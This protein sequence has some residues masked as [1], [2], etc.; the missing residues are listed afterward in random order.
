MFKK[1]PLKNY[2]V[3]ES[4]PDFSDNTYWLFRYMAEETNLFDEFKCIWFLNDYRKRKKELCGVNIKCVNRNSRKVWHSFWRVYYSWLAKI[5]VDC[6]F[7]IY[8]KRDE[9]YRI[10]LTHGMPVKIPDSYMKGIGCCDLLPVSGAGYS[11]FFSKYVEKKSIKN[12][13]LPRND[14]LIKN[15]KEKI[16]KK[17]IVWM[18]TFRQHRTAVDYKID[19]T[20]PLGIPVLKSNDDI[21]YLNRCLEKYRIQIMFRPHPAQDISFLKLQ[22]SKNIVIANDAYLQANNIQLYEF[23]SNSS[24]LIT[25]YSSIY[26][27]YLF[28]NRP[29]GLTLEDIGDF[30][31]KWPMFFHNM[32]K[33]VPGKKLITVDDLSSFIREVAEGLDTEQEKRKTFMEVLGMEEK[34]SCKEIVNTLFKEANL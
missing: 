11:D 31:K 26:L 23:V 5:I 18:P 24:A 33:S 13:G 27:D 4:H 34:E 16:D 10:H 17:Y 14:I 8:K 15:K 22:Q 19:N 12:I 7:Y 29:I 32:E 6:N 25:D 20:F 2:I 28:L 30:Q 9:Q 1:L 3:F 21:E